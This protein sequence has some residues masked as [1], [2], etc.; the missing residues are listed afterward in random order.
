MRS[1]RCQM[2][3][4]VRCGDAPFLATLGRPSELV[5]GGSFNV[6]IIVLK[7]LVLRS[8]S[9]L[10]RQIYARRNT[11]ALEPAR[12]PIIQTEQ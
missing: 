12:A 1:V 4:R 7:R 3:S 9:L 11:P 10:P 6:V 2:Y 8:I 5:E